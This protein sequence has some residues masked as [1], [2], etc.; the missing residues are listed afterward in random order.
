MQ[1]QPIPKR[2]DSVRFAWRVLI[3]T[4]VVAGVVLVLLFFWYAADLLML[5][6]AAVLVSILL[7]TFTEFVSQKTG[8]SR[9]LSL[10]IVSLALVVLITLISWMVTGRIA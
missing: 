9:G 4:L 1:E 2:G 6:F 10:T 7:R 8:L 3:A 5:V